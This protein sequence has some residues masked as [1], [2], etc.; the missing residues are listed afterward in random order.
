MK[1]T[2]DD[3]PELTA[4]PKEEAEPDRPTESLVD[5]GT[6]ALSG[7][8]SNTNQNNRSQEPPIIAALATPETE[9]TAPLEVIEVFSQP[10]DMPADFQN[11]AAVGGSVGAVILGIWSI[12]GS[13]I[14]PFSSINGLVGI[15][16]GIWGLQSSRKKMAITGIVLCGIGQIFC[17]LQL[18]DIVSDFFY[19]QPEEI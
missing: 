10:R 16:M 14:T 4:K 19:L 9:T 6:A 18:N 2:N 7:I 1:P 17:F 13:I 11:L 15:L 12:V 8:E 3:Q 5:D